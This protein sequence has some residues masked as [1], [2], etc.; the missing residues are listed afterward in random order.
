MIAVGLPSSL[1][2]TRLAMTATS[3]GP[4]EVPSLKSTWPAEAIDGLC[5]YSTANLRGF[6]TNT[7]VGSRTKQI[8]NI[9]AAA[10]LRPPKRS[11]RSHRLTV[12]G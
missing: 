4:I 12:D 3:Q 10:R 11:K 7:G 5:T 1:A 9:A 2:G 8:I 6:N